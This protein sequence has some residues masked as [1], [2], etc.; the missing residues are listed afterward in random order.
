MNTSNIK[1]YNIFYFNNENIGSYYNEEITIKIVNNIE[2][3]LNYN[4]LLLFGF[5]N[6]NDINGRTILHNIYKYDLTTT[7]LFK[8]LLENKYVLLT[9]IDN[10]GKVPESYQ[11]KNNINKKYDKCKER[12]LIQKISI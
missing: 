7:Y 9:T 1:W 4:Q 5:Y 10:F 8:Y 11:T 6:S 2:N 3:I 12:T